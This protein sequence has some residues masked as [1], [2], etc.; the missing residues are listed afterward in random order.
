MSLRDLGLLAA[1]VLAVSPAGAAMGGCP[2][3]TGLW[4]GASTCLDR[5]L[6]PAC[7]DEQVRWSYR[8]YGAALSSVLA[9]LPTGPLIRRVTAVRQ[10]EP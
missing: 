5:T 10:A 4:R 6:A 2:D 1:A 8:L 7:S 3:I 9:P